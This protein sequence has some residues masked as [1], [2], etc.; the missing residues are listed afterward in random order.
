MELQEFTNILINIT[1]PHHS[2]HNRSEVIIHQ[3][4][5]RSLLSY[6]STTNTHSKT[7]R[8][9][10]QSGTIIRSITCY[11]YNFISLHQS[12]HQYLLVT[13][14]CTS[15]HIQTINNLIKL[16]LVTNNLVFHYL[17]LIIR[18]LAAIHTTS[19]TTLISTTS[20]S[21]RLSLSCPN[22]TF[23]Q[24]MT[25]NTRI[26]SLLFTTKYNIILYKVL[27]FRTILTVTFMI[28]VSW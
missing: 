22:I 15:H 7:N 5:I 8:T 20:G 2:L 3:N 25:N 1:T 6:R 21:L 12:T 27:F 4:N 23:R 10:C 28:E 11:S 14:S 9:L 18:I 16:S 19:L 17:S 24:L 13:W 26:R